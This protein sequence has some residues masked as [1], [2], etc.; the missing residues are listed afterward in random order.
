MN[1]ESELNLE[2]KIYLIFVLVPLVPN[3]VFISVTLI[4]FLGHVSRTFH[5]NICFTTVTHCYIVSSVNYSLIGNKYVVTERLTYTMAKV[6]KQFVT[7]HP[8]CGLSTCA[9]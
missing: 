4:L 2:R 7:L 6:K 1:V 8:Q 5:V 3:L 9:A